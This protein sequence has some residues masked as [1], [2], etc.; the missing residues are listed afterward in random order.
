MCISSRPEGS[1]RAEGSSGSSSQGSDEA[2]PAPFMPPTSAGAL[3]DLCLAQGVS[4]HGELSYLRA[5][6]RQ[7]HSSDEPE[8]TSFFHSLPCL[9]FLCELRRPSNERFQKFFLTL[10]SRKREKEKRECRSRIK[11][12]RPAKKPTAQPLTGFEFRETG[13]GGSLPWPTIS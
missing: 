2:G 7:D 1:R 10:H 5:G 9:H 13:L 4:D 3:R 12:H 6:D 8:L 11:P